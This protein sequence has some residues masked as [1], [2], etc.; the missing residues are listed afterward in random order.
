[1]KFKLG[2][3]LLAAMLFGMAGCSDQNPMA[4]LNVLSSLS[5]Y[6]VNGIPGAYCTT[7]Y[8]G[9]DIDAGTVCV[10]VL[11]TGPDEYLLVTYTTTGGWEL[12]EAHLWVGDDYLDMPQNRKGNP[13]IGNFP[14]QSGDITGQ[15]SHT[16]TVDLAAFGGE[17]GLCGGALLAAAHAALRKE[18]S[19]GSGIYQTETGW[20]DGDRMVERGNWATFFDIEFSCDISPEP[21]DENSETAFAYGCDAADCF[22]GLDDGDGG[23]FNRWGWTNYIDTEGHYYFDI[24]AGAGQCNLDAGTL[25]GELIVEYYAGEATV[26]YTTCGDYVLTE[27]HLYVGNEILPRD[28]NGDWTIA[29]GQY[30]LKHEDL[31]D[32]QTDPYDPVPVTAPFYVVAHAVVKGDYELGSCEEPGCYTCVEGFDFDEFAAQVDGMNGVGLKFKV[33]YPSGGSDAYFTPTSVSFDYGTSVAF[34]TDSWCIDTDHTIGNGTWYCAVLYSS[35]DYPTELDD[36][37]WENLDLVN[38]IL[39][40]DYVGQTSPGGY[41]TYTYGDVQRAIW[42]LVDPNSTSGLGSWD[43]DRVNEILAAAQLVG[44][45]GDATVSY[46][47]P[48]DGVVGVVI[49]PVSCTNGA[50]SNVQLLIAQVLVAEYPS[51]CTVCP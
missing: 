25:V 26:T 37:I 27:T 14:H 12:V 50:Y 28:V 45:L 46:E 7:L 48:C 3:I 4:P 19:P 44:P 38:F 49:K 42:T 23:T 11:D 40:Q 16:F 33:T 5:V 32:V 2:L 18:D 34:T 30:P 6:G 22:I 20:G 24:Y 47:P 21:L 43:V 41:G 13:K 36:T 9:Q 35:Y 15:T 29:P 51:V 31:A 8:A 17:D 10:E 1:M 39:N